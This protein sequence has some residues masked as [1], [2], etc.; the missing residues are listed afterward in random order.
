MKGKDTRRIGGRPGRDNRLVLAVLAA[1][2]ALVPTLFGALPRSFGPYA[3]L[4]LSGFVI[5]IL[6]HLSRSRW[7]VAIG[8]ILI[9]IGAFLL[10]L[11]LRATTSDEPPPPPQVPAALS[12]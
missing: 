11:A 5:G 7:L 4:M 3:T 9:F 12:G 2:S 10:P 1:G 6:G 8:V